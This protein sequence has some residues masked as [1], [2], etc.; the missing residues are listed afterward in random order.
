MLIPTSFH[1]P[2]SRFQRKEY[3]NIEIVLTE[4]KGYGLRAASDISKDAFIYEY[5]G[6]VV[7]HP[8]FMKRI[9]E[10][11]EE[12][13]K[14]FYFMMP[15]KDEYIDATQRGGIGRFAN[16]SCNCNSNCYFAKW[17]TDTDMDYGNVDMEMDMQQSSDDM[18][19]DPSPMEGVSSRVH[20][21]TSVS[22]TPIT[23]P[24][25][26]QILD[27]RLKHWSEESG[28]DPD[29]IRVANG[30]NQLSLLHT[31]RL[32][33][34]H[35]SAH[36]ASC[37]PPTTAVAVQMPRPSRAP[38]AHAD[39]P[40]RTCLLPPPYPLAHRRYRAPRAHL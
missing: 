38:P 23:P 4:K 37:A 3:A 20:P 1:N 6:D 21:P 28:W 16:H 33:S 12:G 26:Q 19:H 17:Q 40:P 31:L 22:V 27:P 32:H 24:Q 2:G 11:A 8:S 36:A 18:D 30:L 29:A 39:T 9:W 14:H 25:Q 35:H 5:I 7:S 15:Q 13:I 34:I 10:Y